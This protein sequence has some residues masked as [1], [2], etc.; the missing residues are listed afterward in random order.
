MLR[1]ILL[2]FAAL[3]A[4]A[5]VSAQSRAETE[6]AFRTWLERTVTPDARARG[7]SARTLATAFD[8][9]TLDW[10][11]PDLAP[12]GAKP[13]REEPQRQ[14]EFS[15][16]ARYF[17]EKKV[18]QLASIGRSKMKEWGKTLTAIERR[19]GVPAE[20]VVAVWGRES[21]FGTAKMP[22]PAIR[23]LATEA[24]MGARKESFYPELLAALQI[25][26]ED[27]ISF[28]ELRSSWAGA[29]GQPQFLPS[30]FL[31]HAVDFDGDGK[32][33]IWKSAPDSLASIANY[34]KLHG[35]VEGAHWGVEAAVPKGVS[36]TLEGPENGLAPSAWSEMGV[37][38]IGGRALRGS[39]PG[40]KA[41]LLG[42]AGTNGP[43][44]IVSENFY[45]L[46][47]YNES[48][49]YALFIGHVADRIAGSGAFS[50][51][52]G[53]APKLTRGDVRAMQKRLEA[54]GYDVGG[55]DGLVGYKTRI[56]IGLVE[57]SRG[58]RATC[59]PSPAFVEALR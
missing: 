17:D 26:E 28:S 5:P 13:R 20:I 3:V 40:P 51:E 37:T 31:T 53:P 59:W 41:H 23:A 45:V 54:M 4:A 50:A 16:P 22:H 46:K 49:L 39:E 58:E 48:D 10:D 29:M 52:W 34:L 6:R 25:L 8:G 47:R 14:A 55:A 2:A 11:L 24:F 36:C 9:L 42:P 21:G 32:R 19:Y 15:N 30:K 12:P 43:R 38:R 44:F 35:W 7:V 1:F 33:D 57:E 18:A 56:A 27:H